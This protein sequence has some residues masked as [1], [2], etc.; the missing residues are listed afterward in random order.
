MAVKFNNL[1]YH[2]L[3]WW[4]VVSILSCRIPDSPVS[5]RSAEDFG[6]DSVSEPIS[7]SVLTYEDVSEIDI[8][9]V[10]PSSGWSRPFMSLRLGLTINGSEIELKLENVGEGPLEVFSYIQAGYEKH[11]DWF[12]LRLE[13]RSGVHYRE[14][15]LLD[16]RNRSGRFQAV[17]DPGEILTH[18][19]N[20]ENWALHTSNGKKAIEKG[21]Y[22]L[23]AS[24][25]VETEQE[26]IW[27]GS[28]E[29]GPFELIIK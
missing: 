16:S 29:T 2:I 4:M 18:Q 17:L 22:K 3:Y 24:Y 14:L 1:F 5:E 21:T 27:Q 7:K 15:I 8:H 28:L 23:Y 11:Y 6:L 10:D 26:G 9:S 19:I 25:I 20:I 12:R 13:D